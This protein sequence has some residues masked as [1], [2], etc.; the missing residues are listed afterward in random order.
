MRTLYTISDRYAKQVQT[1][2]VKQ[3]LA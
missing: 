2:V 3:S 1:R